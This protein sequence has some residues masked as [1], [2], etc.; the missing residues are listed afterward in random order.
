MKLSTATLTVF[1]LA[2]LGGVGTKTADAHEY[3]VLHI[4]VKQIKLEKVINLQKQVITHDRQTIKWYTNH[5]HGRILL[6]AWVVLKVP[7]PEWVTWH[8]KQL[9]WV[10]VSLNEHKKILA[11]KKAEEKRAREK[12]QREAEQKQS[13]ES[14]G[15]VNAWLCIHRYEGSWTDSGD[16]YYGGLQMDQQFMYS[17]G[18]DMINKYGGFANLWSPQDQMIVAQRA[19]SSGRGFSPWP[20]TA[21]YCG[22]FN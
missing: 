6:G 10:W 16:P 2:L 9:R 8:R 21:R 14:M 19:Y 3:K 17:Y 15:N 13:I 12:A 1:L 18:S 7:E 4:N 22:L 5:Y 20:N 11:K